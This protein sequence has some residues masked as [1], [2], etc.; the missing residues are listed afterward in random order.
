MNKLSNMGTIVS[1][2]APKEISFDELTTAVLKAGFDSKYSREMAPRNAF[3]RAARDLADARVIRKLDEDD[4]EVRFQFTKEY[5]AANLIRYDF[6]CMMW[7]HKEHGTIRTD[8][9]DAQELVDQAQALVYEHQGK[10]NRSDITRM[11]QRIFEDRKGDLISLHP[12]GGTY[13]VPDTHKDLVEQVR[14]LLT[15][16]GGKLNPFVISFGDPNTSASVAEAMADHLIQQIDEFRKTC[17]SFSPDTSATVIARRTETIAAMRD[18]LQGYQALLSGYSEQIAAEIDKAENAIVEAIL[19][20][21]A[22][23]PPA[24]PAPPVPAMATV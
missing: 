2:E 21:E 5:M 22:A 15:E 16:L 19:G 14:L 6:E 18:K 11:I 8:T 4:T 1:W 7:L 9:T 13:F 23:I 3:S 17:E 12:N 10:R 20:A 24:P